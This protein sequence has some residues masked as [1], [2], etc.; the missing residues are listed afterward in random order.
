MITGN[1][2]RDMIISAANNIENQKNAINALNVF[3]VP[4]GDTGTN[5]S[6]TISAAAK[7]MRSVSDKNIAETSNQVASALLKGARGYVYA[8]TDHGYVVEVPL[9]YSEMIPTGRE[10]RRISLSVL[11]KKIDF[12]VFGNRRFNSSFSKV[13]DGKLRINEKMYLPLDVRCEK[14]IE[15]E[16]KEEKRSKEK[17]LEIAKKTAMSRLKEEYTSFTLAQT[18][19][20]YEIVDGKLVY[21]CLFSGIENIAQPLEFELS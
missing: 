6:L 5:M 10:K 12:S 13:Y 20:D 16:R 7:T 18:R 9:E 8:S 2:F 14:I 4:D 21:T 1:M 19:E 11:G 17:A 3:P 15:Y